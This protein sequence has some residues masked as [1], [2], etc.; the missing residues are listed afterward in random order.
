MA[1]GDRVVIVTGGANGIG[2]ACARS[3]ARKGAKVVIAD[4]DQASGLEAQDEI[5]SNGGSVLYVQC[6]VSERLDIHNL[7]AGT[8]EEYGRIDVLINNAGI[9]GGGSFLELGEADFDRVLNVNLKGAFLTAQAVAR[10]MAAQIETEGRVSDSGRTYSIINITSIEAVVGTPNHVPYAVSKGALNQLT[11]AMALSLAPLGIHVNAIGPGNINTDILKTRAGDAKGRKKI[12]SRTPLGRIGD[13]EEIS[14]IAIFLASPEASY[15][16]G[17]TI[18]AD[19]GR[20][21]LN[22][23]VEED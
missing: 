23:V 2:L 3:F 22:L 17:Q 15:V 8:L 6:D 14:S 19:G 5:V 13:P 20:L 4:I 1:W 10:Q 16:T 9:V 21:A 11:K 7:I 12:L 18:Y